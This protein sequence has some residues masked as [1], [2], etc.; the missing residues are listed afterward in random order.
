M[1]QN[2]SYYEINDELDKQ[3][4]REIYA[5]KFKDIG[6]WSKRVHKLIFEVAGRNHVVHIEINSR[7]IT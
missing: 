2:I 6:N 5:T 3:E 1:S 4:A 7:G